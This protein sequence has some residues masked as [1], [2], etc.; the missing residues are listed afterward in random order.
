MYLCVYLSVCMY[1]CMRDYMY[2]FVRACVCVSECMHAPVCEWLHVHV[3]SRVAVGE[4]IRC[5]LLL[6]STYSLGQ[7][8]SLTY[9]DLAQ[10]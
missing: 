6:L 4:G 7:G 2:L 1:L 5:L 10:S 9:L 8:L 3:C